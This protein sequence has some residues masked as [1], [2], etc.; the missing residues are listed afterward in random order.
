MF[1]GSLGLICLSSWVVPSPRKPQSWCSGFS[2][3][4]TQQFWSLI[5]SALWTQ[6][7]L[8]AAI[9]ESFFFFFFITNCSNFS[10][11]FIPMAK[12]F[13]WCW[14]HLPPLSKQSWGLHLPGLD[15]GKRWVHISKQLS[16]HLRNFLMKSV[17]TWISYLCSTAHFSS[18]A[19]FCFY[20]GLS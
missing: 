8:V 16:T 17:R 3:P 6:C 2:C 19:H 15:K 5:S 4:S 11:W 20:I 13:R 1:T 14:A 12:D 10:L 7:S 18:T 9:L